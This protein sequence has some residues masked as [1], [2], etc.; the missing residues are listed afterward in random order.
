MTSSDALIIAFATFGVIS[1]YFK[2][3]AA[4]AFFTMAMAWINSIG[5]FPFP[6]LKNCKDL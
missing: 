3:T 6:I 1:L 5:T 4:A 2:L